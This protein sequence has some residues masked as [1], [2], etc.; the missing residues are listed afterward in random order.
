[1][2]RDISRELLEV[3]EPIVEAHGLELVDVG[4]GRGGRGRVAVIVDTPTGDGRV[5]VDE[6]A[7]V[8]RELSHALDVEDVVA[9]SY[10]L[11]VSSPGVDR[12]LAREKDFEQAVGRK[13]SVETG[14][15]LEGRRHFRG[16]LL[17]FGGS[18]LCVQT[19]T[20]L[21]RI[22]FERVTR[23]KAFCPLEELPA[24]RRRSAKR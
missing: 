1:M 15:P 7:A 5:T 4:L 20:G 10:V 9:G 2:Y 17:E 19:D 18:A 23:A 11:E 21:I 16:E 13:V 12:V 24:Q 22:P 14:E 6:C 3:I 8:S